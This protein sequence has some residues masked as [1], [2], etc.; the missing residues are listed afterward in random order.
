[1][2]GNSA[3]LVQCAQLLQSAPTP[4]RKE[5]FSQ[6]VRLQTAQE[7]PLAVMIQAALAGMEATIQRGA[8]RDAI[9]NTLATLLYG[10]LTG[11]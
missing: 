6:V 3:L 11:H 1:M 4:H 9:R 7:R 5:G 2:R 10:A 8:N